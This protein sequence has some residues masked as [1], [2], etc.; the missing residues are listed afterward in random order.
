MF[1]HVI[2]YININSKNDIIILFYIDLSIISINP[3]HS[4][5]PLIHLSI[6]YQTYQTLLF[7]SFLFAK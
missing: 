3:P 2:K 5:Y 6:T 1:F 4:L 7:L